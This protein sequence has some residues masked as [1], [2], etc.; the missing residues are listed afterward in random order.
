MTTQPHTGERVKDESVPG[1]SPAKTL[2]GDAYAAAASPENKLAPSKAPA[3]DEGAPPAPARRAPD[4]LTGMLGIA[5]KAGK[6]T[7]GAEQTVARARSAR[8]P[9]LILLS[10]DASEHTRRRVRYASDTTRVPLRELPPPYGRETLAHALGVDRPLAVLGIVDKGLAAAIVRRADELPPGQGRGAIGNSENSGSAGG[11]SE[12]D[13]PSEQ[14]NHGKPE[15]YKETATHGKG[16]HPGKPRGSGKGGKKR[17][18]GAPGMAKRRDSSGA[19]GEP[20]AKENIAGGEGPTGK[21][22]GDG[23]PGST[24]GGV[25]HGGSGGAAVAGRYSRRRK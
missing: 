9:S 17:D 8:P 19:R 20:P 6:V 11:K 7:Y 15:K 5:A 2:S 18:H 13:K 16:E 22:G 4:R 10:C 23:K 1:R 25:P 21:R 12:T 24:G 3:E 14:G